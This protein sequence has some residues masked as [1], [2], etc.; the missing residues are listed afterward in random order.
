MKWP[1]PETRAG[2]FAGIL[3]AVL[4][5]LLYYLVAYSPLEAAYDK[6]F[7]SGKPDDAN[8]PLLVN[9][10]IP[11]YLASFV[12]REVLVSVTNSSP[13]ETEVALTVSTAPSYVIMHSPETAR[14]GN[15]DYDGSNVIAFGKIP[16]H[17]TFTRSLLVKA[18]GGKW[19][20]QIDFEFFLRT[21]KPEDEIWS[22]SS[23]ALGGPSSASIDPP[24][25]FLQSL[26]KTVLLPPWSNGF[27]PT[28]ALLSAA[29]LEHRLRK[30]Q[31]E[32]QP[33]WIRRKLATFSTGLPPW[34]KSFLL[35]RQWL[36]LSGRSWAALGLMGLGILFLVSVVMYLGLQ[37]L[38]AIPRWWWIIGVGLATLFGF[39]FL[40]IIE[41][42]RA[43]T[44]DPPLGTGDIPLRPNLP[45]P[46]DGIRHMTQER[47]AEELNDSDNSQAEL[48][49]FTIQLANQTLPEFAEFYALLQKPSGQHQIVLKKSVQ[50]TCSTELQK[51]TGK[52]ETSKLFDG[53]LDLQQARLRTE[54]I[55]FKDG[56]G[57]VKALVTLRSPEATYA[58]YKK[59]R[60]K[61][62]KPDHQHLIQAIRQ[63]LQD[64]R[65]P[66]RSA[67]KSCFS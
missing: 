24:A 11:K 44:D 1:T 18:R 2:W 33:S 13:D 10:S 56:V 55:E 58:L 21:K 32:T 60:A 43:I 34:L 30:G 38:D 15:S 47:L 65:S 59:L 64:A 17:T 62:P 41:C 22:L 61:Q 67:A 57:I 23:V 12:E 31:R 14:T 28:L 46:I 45:D 26:T 20:D 63:A 9:V 4:T 50:A 36:H 16:P 3:L 19:G 54:L 27:L 6:A 51:L 25:A 53:L 48:Q 39:L 37:L 35:E 49:F 42:V 52:P 40:G 66:K 29:S 5:F 7:W 8:G